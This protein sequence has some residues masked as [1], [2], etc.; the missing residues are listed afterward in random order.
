MHQR[1]ACA[2]QALPGARPVPVQLL[3]P[4]TPKTN[5]RQQGCFH[6]NG[7]VTQDFGTSWKTQL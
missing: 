3:A 1:S 4:S 2:P 5:S 6:G 7:R